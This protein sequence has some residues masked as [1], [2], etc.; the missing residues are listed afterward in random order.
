MLQKYITMLREDIKEAM[1]RRCGLDELN[2]L[3]MLVGFLY[4]VAALFTKNKIFL[5][6][7][8]AFVVLCYLRVFSKNV[9]KRKRENDF[10]MRYM[11]KV[12][13]E[14]RLLKLMTR[15]KCKSILDKEYVYFV[16]DEC[17]QVIRVPKGKNKVNIRCPKCNH[18]FVKRT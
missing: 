1:G 13:L 12:V 9:D 17:H 4:V 15:M 16:C 8:A 6:L 5:L 14:A 11:G 18:T 10:Y 7:G 3:I 2:N